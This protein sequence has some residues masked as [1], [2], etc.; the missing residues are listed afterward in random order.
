MLITRIDRTGKT[1]DGWYINLVVLTGQQMYNYW[2]YTNKTHNNA[3]QCT[4]AQFNYYCVANI[5]S[6][7]SL[8]VFWIEIKAPTF[9]LYWT[10]TILLYL[11][12]HFLFA[13]ISGRWIEWCLYMHWQW[14]ASH[15]KWKCIAKKLLQS[16]RKQYWSVLCP[17][18]KL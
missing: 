17:Q 15:N 6:E 8:S 9:G 16:L 14:T 18:I 4:K 3:N 13:T 11:K 7:I 12:L 10:H 2:M 1:K 5:P